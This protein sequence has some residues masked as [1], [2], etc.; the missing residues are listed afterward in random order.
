MSAV[1]YWYPDAGTTLEQITLSRSQWTDIQEMPEV[2]RAEAES[3]GGVQGVST[4]AHPMR[5][6]F[7]FQRFSG[8]D[9]TG[10]SLARKLMTLQN[11]LDRGGV[12]YVANVSTKAWA[13]YSSSGFTRGTTSISH[14][15]LAWGLYT[16][17]TLANGDE[18]VIQS[19]APDCK[20]EYGTV[21]ALGS[22]TLTLSS[23]LVFSYSDA[24]FIR[25]RD[26]YVAMRFP[27]GQRQN[28]LTHDYRRLYTLDMTLEEDLPTIEAGTVLSGGGALATTT[29]SSGRLSPSKP[30]SYS[31]SATVTGAKPTLGASKKGRS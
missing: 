20:R 23:G 5:A 26:F 7:I 2:R 31:G 18:V 24:F 21:S 22:R 4:Y 9:S 17:A 30:A 11:H 15:G 1:I 29:I 28:I 8:L 14:N 27:T 12:C 13:G 25:H 6:R 3:V 19:F 10:Q 16:S